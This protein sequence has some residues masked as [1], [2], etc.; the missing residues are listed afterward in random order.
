MYGGDDLDVNDVRA[1][2]SERHGIG[3]AG[4][5]DDL[6]GKIF[7]IGHMAET[8]RFGPQVHV[9]SAL[10]YEL[11]QRG[12]KTGTYPIEALITSWGEE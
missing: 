5:L 8:A 6:N 3:V 7:R 12:I 1:A 10:A 2:L 4:G 9:V 11:E